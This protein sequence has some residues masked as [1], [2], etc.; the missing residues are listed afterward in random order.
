[1]N[2]KTLCAV[3][4]TAAA[5]AAMAKTSTPEGWTDDYDA[6]LKQAAEENKYVIADFSGSDWCGWCKKLDKEVFAKK[7]F[8]DGAKEKYVL[9][10]IDTP[11]NS[12]LLS[13][14]AKTQNPELVKKYDIQGFPSVLILDAKGE[15]VARTGYKKGGPAKYLEMLETT[16]KIETDPAFAAVIKPI[17][18]AVKD[19]QKDFESRVTAALQEAT[20]KA[21][22][23]NLPALKGLLSELS[24][25]EVPEELKSAKEDALAPLAGMVDDIANTIKEMEK[26]SKG[27]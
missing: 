12:A 2:I 11:N 26:E 4:F 21:L 15:V 19:A 27:E 13:E 17:K 7:E 16:I 18:T 24:A 23:E 6:A 22:S 25:Q 3:G 10:M 20:R 8:L 5:F 1:M 9:L 14:K